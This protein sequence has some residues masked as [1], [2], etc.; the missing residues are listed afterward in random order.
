MWAGHTYRHINSQ[1]EQL[2]N[3][4]RNEAIRAVSVVL[5][6]EHNRDGGA[7]VSSRGDVYS[8]AGYAVAVGKRYN[9]KVTGREISPEIVGEW[10][11]S[12]PG[13]YGG[14]VFDWG[15]YFGSWY[16]KETDT[17]ELDVSEV[18]DGRETA[19]KLAVK[20]GEKAIYAFGIG[21][22]IRVAQA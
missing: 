21:E 5:S 16:D 9:L 4:R 7:T 12:I 14:R 3:K 18:Y 2:E 10:L 13:P 19:A 17:T 20:R 11:E 8:G 1:H 6:R 15:R 22:E